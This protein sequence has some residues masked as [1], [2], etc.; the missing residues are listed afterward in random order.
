[1][2]QAID[3]LKRV[4]AQLKQYSDYGA[5]DLLLA[6]ACETDTHMVLRCKTLVSYNSDALLY[7]RDWVRKTIEAYDPSW[8]PNGWT[9]DDEE[10]RTAARAFDDEEKKR[11]A[12][13]AIKND[14]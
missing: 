3:V 4:E 9:A 6:K 11:A 13:A 14:A 2:E 8:R 7:P 10:G 1:M 5:F 12:A